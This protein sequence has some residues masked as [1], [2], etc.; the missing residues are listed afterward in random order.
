[1]SR[2][3]RFLV[4]AGVATALTAIVAAA[5]PTES[6][7]DPLCGERA[8]LI[9]ALADRYH[10]SPKSMGLSAD[11]AVVEVL[12]STAGNWTI[13]I[14]RPDGLACMMASGESWENLPQ[15]AQGP[16]V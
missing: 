15:M 3:H 10:E 13:L 4:H 6:A 5:M 1:M 16:K 12:A 9:S 7:A 8:M 2:K 14:T 11:G